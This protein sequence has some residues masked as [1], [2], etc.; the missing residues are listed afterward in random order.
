MAAASP[1]FLFWNWK[2]SDDDENG[3]RQAEQVRS[4][5]SIFCI[6]DEL[7]VV[8]TIKSKLFLGL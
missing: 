4:L 8:L 3:N 1:L 6:I 7:D 2:V 5:C